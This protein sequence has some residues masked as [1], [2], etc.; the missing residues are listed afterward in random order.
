MGFYV[1][2][3][4]MDNKE[5]E[6]ARKVKAMT[7]QQIIMKAI[8]KEITWIQAAEIC[9]I[10]P[11]QMRRLKRGYKEYG[12]DFLLDGRAGKA[13]RKRI[14]LKIVEKIY[15]LKTEKYE[16]FSVKHF[17]EQLIEKEG[18]S[19]SYTWLLKVLQDGGLAQKHPGRGK[20]H[21]RRERKPMTGM[22]IHLDAST[23]QWINGLPKWDL[24]I[25]LDDADGRILHGEFHEEEGT[26]STFIA[27][28]E[29]LQKYGR[30]VA[31]YTDRGSHFC[32]TTKAL[33][34][35]DEIQK[36]AVSMALQTL[37]IRHILA[38][39]PQARG[40]SERAFGTI[41]G[42]LPQELKLNNIDNYQDANKYLKEV[43]I[44]SFNKRFSVP[45][46]EEGSAFIPL[47]GLDLEVI[48]SK[49]E[50]RKVG[51]DNT[52]RYKNLYLQIPQVGAHAHYARCWV[53][54][55]EFINKTLAI[56]FNGKLLAKYTS[57]GLIM[58]I[59]NEKL[60]QAYNQ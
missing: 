53:Q 10:S 38:R 41:Q 20:Y 45:T 56:S 26:W 50:K 36:G 40:R 58:D 35:P 60:K 5:Q 25:V 59:N 23:H 54:V 48:L 51:N 47:I 34:G 14:D 1:S 33:E 13:R 16:D 46:K 52:V 12:V 32:T 42:R 18:I 30:F 22:L 29:V 57:Q 9:R 3:Y 55:H 2:M 24:N 8:Q 11:R 17:H 49:K 39:T 37:G 27:L 28:K 31:F 43:F 44:P 4:F 19:I 6:I 7:R 15:L 21:R